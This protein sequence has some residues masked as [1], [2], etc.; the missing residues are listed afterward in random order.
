MTNGMK[1][2]AVLRTMILMYI[3]TAIC[4]LLVS[5]GVYKLELSEASVGIFVIVIYLAVSFLG[6]L[7]TGKKVKEKKFLWGALFGFLYIFLVMLASLV[8]HNEFDILS[9]KAVTS[10]I[11]C[12]SGGLLGGMFG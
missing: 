7:L 6:G 11:L 1:I 12:V 10:M 3:L 9:T 2:M 5:F 4:L 8:M